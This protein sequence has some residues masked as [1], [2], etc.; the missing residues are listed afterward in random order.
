MDCQVKGAYAKYVGL[1]L[2]RD[3]VGL[4]NQLKING[5]NWGLIWMRTLS[6]QEQAGRM[7]KD[8]TE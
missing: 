8:E 5:Y 2:G 6:R 7:R 4:S 3:R 1:R